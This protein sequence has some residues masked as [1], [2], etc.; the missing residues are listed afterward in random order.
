MKVGFTLGKFA[1]LH[2]GHQAVIETSLAEMDHTIVMIYDV[3]NVTKV[4]LPVRAAW[5]RELYPSVE[6]MEAWDGPVEVGYTPEITRRHDEYLQCRLRHRQ[7]THFYSSE[8]YGR[9][10][11]R[12]LHA[13]NRTVDIDR[14]TIPISGSAIRENPYQYRKYLAPRVYRDLV[15]SVAIM[16]APSTGKTT[17]AEALAAQYSTVWMPEYGREYWE[18]HQVDRRLTKRQLLEIAEGH[19]DA[20]KSDCPR[21]P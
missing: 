19:L 9:H 2:R 21:G 12:A 16:G 14:Q 1:P 10:V 20:G 3:P 11:S 17:L 13:V 15:T 5:I 8:P 4:P 7:I 6:I 18:Q